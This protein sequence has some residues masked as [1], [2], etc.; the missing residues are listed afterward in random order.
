MSTEISKVDVNK[1]NAAIS[2][3]QFW[4]GDNRGLC[5]QLTQTNMF[6]TKDSAFNSHFF[7]TVCLTKTQALE[8]AE[9]LLAWANTEEA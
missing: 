7:N 9:E 3:T 1:D 5:V 8:L 6:R 2:L 4:G